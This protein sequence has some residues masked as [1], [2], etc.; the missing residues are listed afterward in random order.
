VNPKS[1]NAD[2]AAAVLTV[3]WMDGS[4]N[5]LPFKLLSDMCPCELCDHERKDDNPL[6]ILRPR[7]YELEAINP[8]GSYAVN[9]IWK[10]GCRYGIYS[11]TYLHQLGRVA[12]GGGI[13]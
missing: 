1:I 13:G 9:I 8:V 11:Y 12:A 10:G 7:S 3:T 2:R 5:V 4:A 6:K